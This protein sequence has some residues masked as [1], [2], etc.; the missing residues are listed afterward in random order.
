[1][2]KF[3]TAIS[4]DKTPIFPPFEGD[5]LLRFQKGLRHFF[6]QQQRP[7]RCKMHVLV[8]EMRGLNYNDRLVGL[9]Q[10]ADGAVHGLQVFA[11]RTRIIGG[12]P[13]ETRATRAP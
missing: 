13:E 3:G 11:E 8:G 4:A 1:M 10:G 9:G 5:G 6:A 7:L 2:S 12:M